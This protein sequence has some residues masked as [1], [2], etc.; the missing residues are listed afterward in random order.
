MWRNLTDVKEPKGI[1]AA[2]Q[3]RHHL[4]CMIVTEGTPMHEH[5]TAFR[6]GMEKLNT[7]GD[8]YKIPNRDFALLL[9][10]SLPKSWDPFMTSY[11]GSKADSKATTITSSELIE[12]LI[13]EDG[14]RHAKSADNE[15]ANATHIRK[16]N[17]KGGKHSNGPA[18]S[19]CGQSGHTIQD[20]WSKG[21]GK[22]GQGPKQKK[23]DKSKTESANQTATSNLP[24]M[25]YM[26][27][28]FSPAFRKDEWLADSGTTSHIATR[29]DMFRDFVPGNTLYRDSARK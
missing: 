15:V 11:F 4:F 9:I 27:K 5:V 13:S 17:K 19:N 21:G 23:K 10:M 25:A 8:E 1:I 16:F 18:C 20:C 3:A 14:R 12:L 7:M 24:D 29:C 28:Q 2:L 6:Q 26:A 22:E